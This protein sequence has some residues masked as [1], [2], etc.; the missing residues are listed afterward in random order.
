M[1]QFG[2]ESWSCLGIELDSPGRPGGSV[3]EWAL[4][5]DELWQVFPDL[6]SYLHATAS[7]LRAGRFQ[8][9]CEPGDEHVY[10]DD[11]A[12]DN[13]F[14]QAFMQMARSGAGHDRYDDA[15]WPEHWRE[16]RRID[17]SRSW[18]L[19][20][21]HTIAQLIADSADRPRGR[22]HAE[23]IAVDPA[24]ATISDGTGEL[25]LE[26]DDSPFAPTQLGQRFEFDLTLDPDH[27]PAVHDGRPLGSP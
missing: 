22:I 4:D 25:R 15:G 21:T 13:P 1:L 5:S 17:W 24:G 19:G 11:Q 27:T 7:W 12:D 26:R 14:R 8:D 6:S 2:Y 9:G 20:V 16:A 10:I 23:A 18:A 3:W